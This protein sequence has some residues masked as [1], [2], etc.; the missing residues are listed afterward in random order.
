[1]NRNSTAQ[2]SKHEGTFHALIAACGTALNR[3]RY[4]VS[5]VRAR[6]IQ[7]YGCMAS[8]GPALNAVVQGRVTH[9]VYDG[10]R[11]GTPVTFFILK[12]SSGEQVWRPVQDGFRAM[13]GVLEFRD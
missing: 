4:A 3:L 13:D 12:T 11:A 6:L 10:S 7:T 5:P 9:Q 2:K 1:M 8:D